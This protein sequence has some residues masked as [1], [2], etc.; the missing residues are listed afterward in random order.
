MQDGT[1]ANN[2][3]RMSFRRSKGKQKK[4]DWLEF[5]LHLT[6]ALLALLRALGYTA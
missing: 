1:V 2:V 6:I 3:I 4:M 5:L